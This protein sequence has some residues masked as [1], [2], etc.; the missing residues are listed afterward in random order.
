[1]DSKTYSESLRIEKNQNSTPAEIETSSGAKKCADQFFLKPTIAQWLLQS[2]LLWAFAITILRALR[3]PNDWAEA[4]WLISYQFGFIKRG[5]PGTLLAPLVSSGVLHEYTSRVVKVSATSIFLLFCAVLFWMCVRMIKK[6]R[7]DQQSVLVSFVFLTSPYVVMSAHLNGYYDNLIILLSVSACFLV[8]RGKIVLSAILLSAGALIHETILIIG[9]PAVI[10][11]ALVQY[12]QEAESSSPLQFWVYFLKRYRY[13]F[14]IPALTVMVLILYQTV[15]LDSTL[16]KDQHGAYLSQFQF[17]KKNRSLTVPR[18]LT[19][20]FL[21]FLQRESPRFLQRITDFPYLIRIGPPLAVLLAYAWRSLQKNHF[22]KGL[23]ISLTAMTLLPLSLH[24]IAWDT[25]RIWTYPLVAALFGVWA[26]RDIY[27]PRMDREEN[28]HLF[29][30]IIALV[31]IVS[32]MFLVT[33]LMDEAHERFSNE[34]RLLL[35]AP[36]LI[37]LALFLSKE[38]HL[39]RLGK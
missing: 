29:F 2:A 6:T 19:T 27:Y 34:I 15:F 7:Y 14:L 12:I 24:L 25:S 5:L 16:I 37:G 10:F 8:M 22:K 35:Y 11:L 13:L 3:W 20:P 36:A 31:V 33:P 26:I 4:H 32:Q 17:I 38:Y 9:F 21:D 39:S 23:F 1:M 18:E 28:A 30:S